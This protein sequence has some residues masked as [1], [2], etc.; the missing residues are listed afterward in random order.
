METIEK[1]FESFE[2]AYA[3]LGR[4]IAL[5]YGYQ[6][7]D[8]DVYWAYLTSVI[9]NFELSYETCWKLLQQILWEEHR[10]VV[11]SPRETFRKSLQYG[12][13]T[14]E[15]TDELLEFVELRNATTHAY[16]PRIAKGIAS[17]IAKHAD[18]FEKV[19]A[20]CRKFAVAE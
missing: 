1:K 18:V 13:V 5:L 4:M 10:V 20:A 3:A 6:V 8:D 14:E 11:N 12:L 15:T 2:L 19:L 16:T 17:N 7:K 9:K